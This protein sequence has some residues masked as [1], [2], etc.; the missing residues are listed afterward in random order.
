MMGGSREELS[1][2]SLQVDTATEITTP[3]MEVD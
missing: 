2:L 3:D 1:S